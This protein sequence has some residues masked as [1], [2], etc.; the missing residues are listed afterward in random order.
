MLT[1]VLSVFMN[2]AQESDMA[3]S[4]DSG[5]G[6]CCYVFLAMTLGAVLFD[7]CL[8]RYIGKDIPWYMDMICGLFTFPLCVPLAVVGYCLELSGVPSPFLK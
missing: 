4:K 1:S 2:I 3:D 8:H 5:W 7:Y 6:G